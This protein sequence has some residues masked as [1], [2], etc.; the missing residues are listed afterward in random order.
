MPIEPIDLVRSYLGAGDSQDYEVF[1]VTFVGIQGRLGLF[2]IG[3]ETVQLVAED[4]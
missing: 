3:T 2:E 4:V 1:E